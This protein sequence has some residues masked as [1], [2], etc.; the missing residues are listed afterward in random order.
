[1]V[2]TLTKSPSN[3]YGE[4]V[5]VSR[6]GNITAVTQAREPCADGKLRC[7]AVYMYVRDQGHWSQQAKLFA[8]D[9]VQDTQ[10]GGYDY[11][12]RTVTLND[13]GT[14]MAVATNSFGLGKGAVY[15]FVRSGNT[16]SEQQKLALPTA[17]LPAAQVCANDS[18]GRSLALSGDGNVLIVGAGNECLAGNT[19]AAY[20]FTKTA[21][22]WTAQTRLVGSRVEPSGDG[23]TRTSAFGASVDISGDGSTLLVGSQG[24]TSDL[25]HAY[26][27]NKNAAGTWNEKAI[28]TPADK[29]QR[30]GFGFSVALNRSGNTALV[31][32]YGDRGAAYIYTKNSGLNGIW[33][34]EAKIGANITSRS[35]FGFSFS[36]D[37]DDSGTHAIVGDWGTRK[38][39]LFTRVGNY[40]WSPELID[41][42]GGGNGSSVTISG[43]GTT[44]LDSGPGHFTT[45]QK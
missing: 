11:L 37:L 7:G 8:S 38:A 26:I 18:F 10:L 15:V 21:N 36:L 9:G 44:L 28:L 40:V 22:Q 5:A 42:L 20:L 16:W 17:L 29:P 19:G 25:Q 23:N 41:T 35:S 27:F 3:Q 4:A 14:V 13:D 33:K 2:E 31:G 45:L 6:D 24:L 32:G 43:D 12:D 30:S 39:F 34:Q 1:M